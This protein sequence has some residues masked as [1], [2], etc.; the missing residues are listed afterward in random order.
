MAG[1]E[2]GRLRRDPKEFSSRSMHGGT[3][4]FAKFSHALGD[5]LGRGIPPG[6]LEFGLVLFEPPSDGAN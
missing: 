1:E 4:P 5:T 3:C 2:N 6:G